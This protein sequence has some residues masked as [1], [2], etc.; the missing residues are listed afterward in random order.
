MATKPNPRS[1]RKQAH[2]KNTSKP[3]LKCAQDCADLPIQ[4]F[5][6]D[7]DGRK[8]TVVCLKRR[9]VLQRLALA[10]NTNGKSIALSV[11]RIGESIGISRATTFR[12]LDDLRTLGLLNDEGKWHPTYHTRV[13]AL[14]VREVLN[15]TKLTKLEKQPSQ[16]DRQPSQIHF[17]PSQIDWEP[18]QIAPDPTEENTEEHTEV[19]Y[20]KEHM[21]SSQKIAAQ[22]ACVFSDEEERK[23]SDDSSALEAIPE[24]V[25]DALRQFIEAAGF[26]GFRDPRRDNGAL[27]KLWNLV[28]GSTNERR[29]KVVEALE[30]GIGEAH[31]GQVETMFFWAEREIRRMNGEWDDN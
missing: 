3:A 9:A 23:S 11:E 30:Y 12:I 28:S 10:A 1:T 7:G 8:W 20:R 26:D 4:S 24:A 16:I 21:D 14:D 13:R 27:R 6:L 25:F 18:S 31:D 5:R 17:E 2:R 29:L 22:N 15:R 19:P